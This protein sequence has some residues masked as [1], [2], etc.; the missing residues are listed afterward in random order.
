MRDFD[1]I[2]VMLCI[3]NSDSDTTQILERKYTQGGRK[4]RYAWFEYAHQA[5]VWT[6]CDAC[7]YCVLNVKK[8]LIYSFVLTP[9]DVER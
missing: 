5:S 3:F 8:I 7:K 2:F 6:R 4:F 1:V 9:L